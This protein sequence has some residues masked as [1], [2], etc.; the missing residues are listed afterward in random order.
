MSSNVTQNSP[1]TPPLPYFGGRGR[2]QCSTTLE[3]SYTVHIEERLTCI[4][5]SIAK[6]GVRFDAELTLESSS[7]VVYRRT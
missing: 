7:T 3:S 6:G 4:L 1:P 2:I 5:P